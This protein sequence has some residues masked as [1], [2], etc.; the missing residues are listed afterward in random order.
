M[1]Q[2][3]MEERVS[4]KGAEHRSRFLCCLSSA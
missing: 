1:E 3:R 4:D 2:R